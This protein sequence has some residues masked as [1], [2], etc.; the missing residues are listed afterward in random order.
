MPEE[1]D[2]FMYGL[3]VFLFGRNT[4]YACNAKRLSELNISEKKYI[5]ACS[6]SLEKKD[7]SEEKKSIENK[8]VNLPVKILVQDIVD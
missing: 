3:E 1:N 7:V 5:K 6:I 8:K 4:V 2:E